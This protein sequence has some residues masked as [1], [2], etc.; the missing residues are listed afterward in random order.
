MFIGCLRSSNADGTSVNY[1]YDV[2]N[3]VSTVIDNRLTFGTTTY[4]YDNAGNLQGYLY[5]NGVQTSYT[6]NTLNRLTNVALNKGSA[7]ASYAYALGAAG[8]RTAVT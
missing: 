7:L 1:S 6:Y 8:N 2:L 4:S 5:P 3:R